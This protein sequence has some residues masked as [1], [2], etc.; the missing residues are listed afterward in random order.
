MTTPTNVEA[1]L[2]D[3]LN[4]ARGSSDRQ[5]QRILDAIR[6]AY[7]MALED[8]H[9]A[10]HATYARDIRDVEMRAMCKQEIRALAAEVKR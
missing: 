5:N 10:V 9:E 1:K 7:A 3:L 2:S 6:T 8:A 4:V